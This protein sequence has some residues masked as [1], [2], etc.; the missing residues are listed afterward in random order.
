MFGSE[1]ILVGL[2]FLGYVLS[3]IGR[4]LFGGEDKEVAVGW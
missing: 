3:G 2:G 4:G 1:E